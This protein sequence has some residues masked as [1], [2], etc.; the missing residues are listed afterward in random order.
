MNPLLPRLGL[1]PD[2]RAVILHV[3]DIGMCHASVEAFTTLAA[4]GLVVTGSV[5]V[6]CPWFPHQRVAGV[7]LAGAF[8]RRPRFRPG[9]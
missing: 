6:P 1:P 9:R 4:G 5:M 3:D 7:P 8:D 2:A